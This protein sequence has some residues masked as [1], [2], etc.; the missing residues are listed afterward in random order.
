MGSV[1]NLGTVVHSAASYCFLWHLPWETSS[2]HH[3]TNW[4]LYWHG[5]HPQPFNSRATRSHW[6]QPQRDPLETWP[7]QMLA[8]GCGHCTW[9]QLHIWTSTPLHQAHPQTSDGSSRSGKASIFPK[10]GWSIIFHLFQLRLAV[11]IPKQDRPMADHGWRILY[12]FMHWR[13][14]KSIQKC[15]V[16]PLL[17]LFS[18]LVLCIFFRKITKF[19]SVS[20][21]DRLTVPPSG[22]L[23]TSTPSASP[24]GISAGAFLSEKW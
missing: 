24:I 5:F 8:Q 4:K 13:C 7:S 20:H 21:S 11:L 6:G 2:K 17:C 9:I 16:I 1:I 10:F 15:L 23:C 14:A 19:I 3:V 22:P 12:H 18:L